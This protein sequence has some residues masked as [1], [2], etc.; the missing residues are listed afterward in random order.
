M[1]SSQSRYPFKLKYL[2]H[3]IL[4]VL[5]LPEIGLGGESVEHLIR[6][7]LS[8]D[9]KTLDLSGA[10]IGLIGAKILAGMGVLSGVETL[11]LQGN[12]VKFKG[13]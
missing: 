6:S 11:L 3:C 13:I 9:G 7:R 10:N 1:L 8:E 4:F 5:F 2:L 12:K